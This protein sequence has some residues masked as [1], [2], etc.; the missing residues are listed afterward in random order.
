MD[1]TPS[2]AKYKSRCL[3]WFR[4]S[5]CLKDTDWV[6]H[7]DEETVIDEECIH[8]CLDMIERSDADIGQVSLTL[9]GKP[10]T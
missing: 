9:K 7:I 3:E 10:E 6:L 4:L 8:A 5:K 2:K 1:F